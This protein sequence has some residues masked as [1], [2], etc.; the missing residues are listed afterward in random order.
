[1]VLDKITEEAKKVA[2]FET[3]TVTAQ[4]AILYSYIVEARKMSLPLSAICEALNNAG[5]KVSERYLREALSVV[6]GRLKA[7]GGTTQSSA[8]VDAKLPVS[9]QTGNVQAPDTSST[10]KTPKEAREEKANSYMTASNP[11]FAASSKKPK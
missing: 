2:G 5:S 10:A 11:L 1:M 4:I 8:T 6:K 7:N 3:L 9:S